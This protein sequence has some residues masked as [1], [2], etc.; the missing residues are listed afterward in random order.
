MHTEGSH[1]SARDGVHAV[2][3]G[4]SACRSSTNEGVVATGPHAGTAPVDTISARRG[5]G[6]SP[7][8]EA[9]MA[10]I[11]ACAL[12]GATALATPLLPPCVGDV[13]AE[14]KLLAATEHSWEQKGEVG[15][16][17]SPQIVQGGGAEEGEVLI[18]GSTFSTTA[19]AAQIHS[20][21]MIGRRRRRG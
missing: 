20:A 14:S 2:T 8:E 1:R 13:N 11:A 5:S 9:S 16:A 17:A 4:V 15:A 3:G 19:G 7:V 6:T 18:T 10:S 21:H 12:P